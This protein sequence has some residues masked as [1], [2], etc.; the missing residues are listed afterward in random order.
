MLLPLHG[1]IKVIFAMHIFLRIFKK[2]ELRENMYSVIVS[3]FTVCVQPDHLGGELKQKP[4]IKEMM[5]SAVN[6]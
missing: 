1:I 5:H 4:Y 3:I 6:L 2:H